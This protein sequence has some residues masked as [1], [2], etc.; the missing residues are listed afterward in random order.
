MSR[1]YPTTYGTPAP[2]PYVTVRQPD[3]TAKRVYSDDH[4]ARAK[5]RR[6]EYEAAFPARQE[7]VWSDHDGC[8]VIRT[9]RG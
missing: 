8:F 3:G 2:V 7:R 1:H 5:L 4:E 9:V 6:E